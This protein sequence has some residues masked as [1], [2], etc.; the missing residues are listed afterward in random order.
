M[1]TYPIVHPPL[2]AAL[3]AAGHGSRILVADGNYPTATAVAAG[4]A[5]VWLNVAPGLLDAT[6]VVRLL[7]GAVPVEAAHV[8][9]PDDGSTPQAFTDFDRLLEATGVRCERLSR[10]DFYTAARDAD[11]AA[12]IATGDQRHYANLI[13]TIGVVPAPV[14]PSP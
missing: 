8:M 1:L 6:T 9:A 4:A 14:T 5:R 2:L 10:H 3:A 7:L 11:V 12:V 13:V